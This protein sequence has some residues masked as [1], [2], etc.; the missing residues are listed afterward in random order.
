MHEKS[1][2]DIIVYMDD[3]DYYP[4]TRISHAVETLAQNPQALCAGSSIMHIYFKHINKMYRVWSIWRK[5]RNSR[6]FCI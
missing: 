5:T 3:D 2:G 6:Y 4:P 1:T